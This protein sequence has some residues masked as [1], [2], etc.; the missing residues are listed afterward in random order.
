M[1]GQGKNIEAALEE[2]RSQKKIA[3]GYE[4]LK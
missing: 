3:E 1:L 2:L 4:T